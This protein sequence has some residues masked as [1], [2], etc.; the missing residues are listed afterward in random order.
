MR[1]YV[2]G[3]GASRHVGYPLACQM[4]A[5]LFDWML[6]FPPESD[7]YSAA[8]GLSE[9][10]GSSPN[11]E[12]VI[13]ELQAQISVLDTDKQ[14]DRMER[15]LFAH[16][17]GS[18][19][20]AVREWFCQIREHKALGYRQLATSLLNPGDVVVTFNYDDSLEREL[21]CAGKWDIHCGYGFPVGE[22]AE[23][24]TLVIKLHG[25]IN[26]LASIFDGLRSGMAMTASNLSLGAGPL[27][28]DA[29]LAYLG[30]DGIPGH[31]FPGGGAF[32]AMIMPGRKKEFF[33]K[34]S[35]GAEWM[36]FWN[37]L[38]AEG[39]KALQHA[40]ELVVCGYSLLPVDERACDLIL[41]TPNKRI[42]VTIVSGD[43]SDRIASGFRKHGFR[44]VRAEQGS[45]FEEWVS[46]H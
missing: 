19:V 45:L 38:W 10:F 2:L 25:S 15:A 4:G 7:Y 11:I 16:W 30:Y 35:F 22:T 3:A 37:A 1:V 34:T 40:N 39:A 12:D 21:R 43:Q 24:P 29:D 36:G 33:Y 17:R 20:H 13:T 23:S 6:R 5:D 44:S 31:R 46:T 8:Q 27:I 14:E 18:L 26:W 9:R 42:P 41:E 32:P 28:P